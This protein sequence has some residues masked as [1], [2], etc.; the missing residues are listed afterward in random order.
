[1]GVGVDQEPAGIRPRP[2][3]LP[4]FV[5]TGRAKP[6]KPEGDH[7]IIR[8]V[9]AAAAIALGVT[10]VS[11]QDPI[12][13]RRAAMKEVGGQNRVA[14]ELLD[15]KLAFDLGVAKK[16]LA[17][18]AAAVDRAKDA[19]PA[20]SQSG[21]TNALPAI[22]ENKADFDAKLAKFAAD[23]RAAEKATTDLASFKQQMGMVRQNCGGCHK[24]Y[25][26]AQS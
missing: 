6:K 22:W 11:A 1:M 16:A 7:M 17:T 10:V 3:K 8:T 4:L 18:I 20:N 2:V 19:F 12:G 23:A 13:V 21:D 25:R 5:D 15:G 9:L 24:P 26:K 14:T